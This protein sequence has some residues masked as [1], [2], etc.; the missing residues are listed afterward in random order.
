[1]GK[2]SLLLKIRKSSERLLALYNV[3]FEEFF[4]QLSE[5]Q[6]MVLVLLGLVFIKLFSANSGKSVH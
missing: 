1:M 6:V 5:V 4:G 3:G 2:L